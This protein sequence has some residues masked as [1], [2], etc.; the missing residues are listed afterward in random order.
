MRGKR[1][2]FLILCSR[3]HLGKPTCFQLWTFLPFM[4]PKVYYRTH[5]GPSLD[6][7]CAS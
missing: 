5:K 6:P 4:E 2:N 3:V 7:L 1:I